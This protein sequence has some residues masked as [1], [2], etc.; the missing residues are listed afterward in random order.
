VW[1]TVGETAM[2][3]LK[4]VVDNTECL[5]SA[6]RHHVLRQLLP[7]E[8]SDCGYRPTLRPRRRELSLTNKTRLDE[9]NFIYRLVYKNTYWTE[10]NLLLFF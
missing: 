5:V 6:D 7:P 4:T 10:L 9:Q 3:G 1:S 2:D 8:R